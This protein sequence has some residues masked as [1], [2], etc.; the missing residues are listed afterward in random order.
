MNS[1]AKMA[2]YIDAGML[3]HL[4]RICNTD[5]EVSCALIENSELTEN[6]VMFQDC[7]HINVRMLCFVCAEI[8]KV[9]KHAKH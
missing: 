8:S 7:L 5:T 6:G 4:C 2:E 1:G 3:K 9:L